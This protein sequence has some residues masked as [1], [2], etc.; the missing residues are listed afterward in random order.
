MR[1]L[2]R[3]NLIF[4]VFGVKLFLP[5]AL[6][7]SKICYVLSFL[8]LICTV[9]P[10]NVPN[11]S[12]ENLGRITDAPRKESTKE[13][14]SSVSLP[15]SK[16]L[17]RL[18]S[19]TTSD[20]SQMS[21]KN[22]ILLSVCMVSTLFQVGAYRILSMKIIP[23]EVKGVINGFIKLPSAIVSSPWREWVMEQC[24]HNL[25]AIPAN[26]LYYPSVPL[27]CSK[28]DLQIQKYHLNLFHLCLFR[29]R[30]FK[31]DTNKQHWTSHLITWGKFPT[32]CKFPIL[33][34]FSVNASSSN[35]DFF[36]IWKVRELH[37][38]LSE[39]A[40]LKLYFILWKS[41]S[42]SCIYHVS[43]QRLLTQGSLGMILDQ[44]IPM[45]NTVAP[46]SFASFSS[47]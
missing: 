36:L 38:F 23:C 35:E 30:F 17:E 4:G 32:I 16:F 12:L 44:S 19:N 21:Y 42:M 24:Q 22:E 11:I 39:N 15:P 8:K 20:V 46:V 7:C 13:E 45:R 26:S 31:A 28:I 14:V 40:K 47:M 41:R 10:W 33:I 37:I 43:S 5:P 6:W 27:Q 1:H 18:P 2:A 25:H 9:N 34:L 29:I 3:A